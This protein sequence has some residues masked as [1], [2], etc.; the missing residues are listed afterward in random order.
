M[1]VP[2]TAITAQQILDCQYDIYKHYIIVDRR[3]SVLDLKLK[4]SQA[5]GV[6]LDQLVF[7][8]GGAHGVEL[9]EDDDS[10]KQA[11]FYNHICL[12]LQKGQPSVLGQRRIQFLLARSSQAV[13]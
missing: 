3:I 7:R 1:S 9:L 2:E 8:R 10:L 12:F 4:I 5:V 11:Q 6:S 13:L